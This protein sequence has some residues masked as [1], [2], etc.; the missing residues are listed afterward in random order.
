MSCHAQVSYF[1]LSPVFVFSAK[2]LLLIARQALAVFSLTPKFL[3]ILLPD[4]GAAGVLDDGG[5]AY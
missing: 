4:F 5:V 2:I 3:S 1:F